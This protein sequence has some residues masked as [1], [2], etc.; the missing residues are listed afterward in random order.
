MPGLTHVEGAGGRPMGSTAG[1][2]RTLR[3]FAAEAWEA[4]RTLRL[5]EAVTAEDGP[6]V[7]ATASF[8]HP[9]FKGHITR[10]PAQ[11]ESGRYVRYRQR[12]YTSWICTVTRFFTHRRAG[13]SFKVWAFLRYLVPCGYRCRGSFA[14]MGA[15]S[16]RKLRHLSP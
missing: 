5:Y 16:L 12:C 15:A 9:L 3:A 2:R 14:L 7:L 8:A 4:N 1:G 6:D 11:R 10:T 13:A